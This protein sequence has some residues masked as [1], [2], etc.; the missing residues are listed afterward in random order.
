[1]DLIAWAGDQKIL[2]DGLAEWKDVGFGW[3][4][5]E[6]EVP[7]NHSIGLQPC[8]HAW[9]KRERWVRDSNM[10]GEDI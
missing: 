4:N 1:V 3:Q 2:D 10:L 9:Y 6:N 8:S 7:S 5:G